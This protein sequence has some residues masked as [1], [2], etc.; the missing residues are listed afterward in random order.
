MKVSNSGKVEYLKS[1]EGSRKE[2]RLVNSWSAKFWFAFLV[3]A[4]IKKGFSFL[5]KGLVELN[6]E[7]K[8][9]K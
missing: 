3:Q 9:K 6:L 4:V 7:E 1:F 8:S 5:K 2:E